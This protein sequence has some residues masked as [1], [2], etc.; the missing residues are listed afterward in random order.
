MNLMINYSITDD[1]NTL[2]IEESFKRFINSI[3]KIRS[4][5][6]GSNIP[7]TQFIIQQ[8]YNFIITVQMELSINDINNLFD[9]LIKIEPVFKNISTPFVYLPDKEKSQCVGDHEILK[10][11]NICPG[12]ISDC[13]DG[14]LILYCLELKNI[15]SVNFPFIQ[16]WNKDKGYFSLT[17]NGFSDLVTNEHGTINDCFKNPTK[18]L[19]TTDT[20]YPQKCTCNETKYSLRIK[21]KIV[22]STRLIKSDVENNM[23]ITGVRFV[24][25]NETIYTQI[26]E[27]KL[28]AGGYINQ[29]TVKWKP[30][31]YLS[32]NIID[33][34][35][36]SDSKE[37]IEIDKKNKSINM[38]A[39]NCK[40]DSSIVTGIRLKSHDNR[41]SLTIVCHNVDWINGTLSTDMKTI[42]YPVKKNDKNLKQI[43]EGTGNRSELL[44]NNDH[45]KNASLN[46][47][48]NYEEFVNLSFDG[49]DVMSTIS[50]PISGVEI[51]QKNNNSS[52]YFIAYRLYSIDYSKL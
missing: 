5:Y 12:I 9:Q 27:G 18:T 46:R 17:K 43:V 35:L 47:E 2:N 45:G 19:R 32:K 15:P 48:N 51:Y 39:V 20:C 8:L 13:V 37:F 38:D 36:K 16:V 14:N 31:K 33:E 7:P 40:S 24:K 28:L 1:V 49:Q 26:R 23:V 22:I 29:T 30:I 25:N 21:N 6:C 10:N 3:Q 11:Q 50:V 4:R 41:I 42:I 34:K 52:S 44:G